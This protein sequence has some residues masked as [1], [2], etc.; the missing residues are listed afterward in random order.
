MYGKLTPYGAT[1]LLNG[2]PHP[3]T[4]YALGHTGDPLSDGSANQS[5]ATRLEVAMATAVA[6]EQ[7]NATS[8]SGGPPPT[9]EEWSYVSLWDDPDAG[10]AW[11]ILQ[12]PAPVAITVG[13]LFDYIVRIAGGA[14]TLALTSGA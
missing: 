8:A 2:T 13:G 10:N 1:A 12:L 3:S 14:M 4:F 5:A 11:W 9:S 6:G 7:S